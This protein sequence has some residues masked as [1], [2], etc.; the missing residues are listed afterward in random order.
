MIFDRLHVWWTGH[1]W[2]PWSRF[3]RWCHILYQHLRGNW[4]HEFLDDTTVLG[5]DLPRPIHYTAIRCSC[6]RRF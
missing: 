1:Q 5:E 4:L 3:H 6:G 2:R